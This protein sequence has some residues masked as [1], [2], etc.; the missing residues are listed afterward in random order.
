M[1]WNITWALRRSLGFSG[2]P[3]GSGYISLYIPHRVTIQ[4]QYMRLWHFS[5]IMLCSFENSRFYLATSF[6]S[7]WILPTLNYRVFH[8]EKT[9]I[10][11]AGA[12]SAPSGAE[13]LHCVAARIVDQLQTD[14]KNNNWTT[15]GKANQ[16]II[17][18]RPMKTRGCST[19][20]IVIH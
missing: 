12:D 10:T 19:N 6:F 15:C 4:I 5:C 8:L 16:L 9:F 7:Q 17:H 14:W 18:S 13:S 1:W 3:S 2:F 20:N 11:I